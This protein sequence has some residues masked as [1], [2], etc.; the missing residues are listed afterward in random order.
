MAL[1]H[2]HQLLLPLLILLLRPALA[3]LPAAPAAP[4]APAPPVLPQYFQG[5]FTEYTAP[6]TGPPPYVNGVPDAPFVA[7]RG[8]VYYDWDLESMIEERHDYCVN[9][10]SF[11][12]DFPCTFQNVNG[13]SYLITFN[14][15]ASLPPCCV[16]GQPWHPPRP[17][18]LRRDPTSHIA[19]TAPWDGAAMN[20]WELPSVPAPTGPFFYTFWASA[21]N[22]TAPQV[23]HSFSFPGMEGWIQQNFF[24]IEATKPHPSVWDLPEECLP[25]DKLQNCGFFG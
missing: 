24:N 8:F 3:S 7:S 23:Y 4:G 13:T 9:I 22:D 25:V 18:F 12:N 6:L 11:G 14:K 16:F 2:P 1:V 10:F 19:A 15:T 20:W 21:L 5:N 17:D